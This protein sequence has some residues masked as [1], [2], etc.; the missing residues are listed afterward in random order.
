MEQFTHEGKVKTVVIER[1][2]PDATFTELNGGPFVEEVL[3][4]KTSKQRDRVLDESRIDIDPPDVHVEVGGQLEGENT[5][6]LP[7]SRTDDPPGNGS[8]RRPVRRIR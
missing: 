4:L 5:E 7:T 1:E 2:I 8:I 3:F 6:P